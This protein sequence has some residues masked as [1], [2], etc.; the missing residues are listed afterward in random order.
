[1]TLV[2]RSSVPFLAV[3]AEPLR[4]ASNEPSSSSPSRNWRMFSIRVSASK[5]VT[6]PA[7]DVGTFV[8]SPI[9]N[10]GC[11]GSSGRP[12]VDQAS[13]EARRGGG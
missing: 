12:Y 3:A 6:E 10:L 2:R 9:A 7:L 5:C 11:G 1:M 13:W 4:E 8:A